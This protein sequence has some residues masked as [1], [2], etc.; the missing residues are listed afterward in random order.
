VKPRR[1]VIAPQAQRD[2][3][4][5][6]RWLAEARGREFAETWVLALGEWLE[7]QAAHGAVIGTEHPARPG[8]RTFGY[9][10]QATVLAAFE[11]EALIVARFYMRGRDWSR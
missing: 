1:L 3:A 7:R 9:R 2:I 8:F 5:A 4:R 10:R 6:A 11:A